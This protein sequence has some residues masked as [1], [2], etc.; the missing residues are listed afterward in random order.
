LIAQ[1]YFTTGAIAQGTNAFGLVAKG[2][3]H[4]GLLSS[5]YLATF[6]EGVMFRGDKSR[7]W[8]TYILKVFIAG[9]VIS[10]NFVFSENYRSCALIIIIL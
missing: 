3:S 4:H 8:L 7:K 1:G 5:S 2:Q 6:S 10:P 9:F